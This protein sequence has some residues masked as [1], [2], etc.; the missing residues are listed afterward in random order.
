MTADR[1]LSLAVVQARI[2][3]VD[4]TVRE[5]DN[6]VRVVGRK[7]VLQTLRRTTPTV[8]KVAIALVEDL[9]VLIDDRKAMIV[10]Q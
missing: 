2:R 10:V 6:S 3:D 8:L 9:R 1:S 7:Y 4:Q 5:G